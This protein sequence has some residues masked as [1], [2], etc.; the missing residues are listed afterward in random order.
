MRKNYLI[1]N[2]TISLIITLLLGYFLLS[3]VDYR[4]IFSLFESINYT[5]IAISFMFY[6]VL[7]LVRSL[8]IKL[9]VNHNTNIK[10]LFAI[11][12]VNN[13][14]INL[15]PFRIGELSLPV[16]LSRYSGVEKKEG[17]LMLFYLRV[18]D[19]FVVL[20]LL[21]VFIFLFSNNIPQFYGV[22]LSLVL[23][24]IFI[25]LALLNSD[26]I[27]LFFGSL[28]KKNSCLGSMNMLS[29][30]VDKLLSV[31]KFYK[32]KIAAIFILSVLTFVT[33]IFVLGFVI[34]A[35]PITLSFFDTVL[36]SLVV[37]IITSLPVNGI[38]GTGPLEL[39]IST[40]L[41]SAGVDKDLSISIAFNYHFV[42]LIFIVF[43]GSLS[44]LYLLNFKKYS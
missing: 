15:L 19:V 20:M 21:L 42:Y 28:F 12:L 37:I 9:L 30:S 35:Y 2:A 40:I 41:V 14:V 17:F 5:Y 24:L 44:Y 29:N 43:F 27:L 32:G 39:G 38:A 3:Q 22:L 23:L 1:Y 18:M 6:F 10:N 11:V 36:V 8:R 33:L 25:I 34:K 13:F 26:K 31:N 16:L 4:N 7:T